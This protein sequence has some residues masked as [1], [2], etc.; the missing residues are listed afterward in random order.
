MVN[1]EGE[2]FLYIT[3]SAYSPVKFA[4][5]SVIACECNFI[6][7]ILSRNIQTGAVASVVGRRVRRSHF[8]LETL[9]QLL[10]ANDLSKCRQIFLLHLSDANSDERRMKLEVQQAAGIPTEAC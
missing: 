10:K 3:D 9:I 1:K 2:A 7:D 4:N 6:S 8:S 5:L